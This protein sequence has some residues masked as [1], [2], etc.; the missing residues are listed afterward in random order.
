MQIYKSHGKLLLTGEYLVLDGGQALAFPTKY[1]QELHISQQDKPFLAWKSIN[2]KN[3][4]WFNAEFVLN[5]NKEFRVKSGTKQSDVT[6][7]LLKLLNAAA[8]LNP[9][10]AKSTLNKQVTTHLDFPNNWGLGSSSTL[11]NNIAQWAQINPFELLHGGF[12]GSGYDV[13]C[14]SANGPLLYANADKF[15]PTI[16]EV[17][18]NWDFTEALFFVHLNKKKDSK[19]GILDYRQQP[20]PSA[21]TF[22][23]LASLNKQFLSCDSILDFNL[24]ITQHEALIGQ[25]IN[26][27]RVKALLFKDY[28]LGAIK[29][30]GAW[31]GDFILASGNSTTPAYFNAK[32]YSSVIPF[33]DM[34]LKNPK[35]DE[36][37]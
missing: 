2:H 12:G 36:L 18:L 7:R 17:N 13:A 4:C 5:Q 11:I 25:T 6:T 24:L 26:Q 22:E 32:G 8:L 29:S 20:T 34:L 21:T 16:T 15:N 1:G 28:E 10:F 19:S 14:A 37:N 3:E 31:G 33:N 35:T 9:E 23:V 27:P 30:L